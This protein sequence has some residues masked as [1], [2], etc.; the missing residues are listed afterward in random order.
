M[1]SPKIQNK[2]LFIAFTLLVAKAN[3]FQLKED[4]KPAEKDPLR[5]KDENFNFRI[6]QK[7]RKKSLWLSSKGKGFETKDQTIN[8]KFKKEDGSFDETVVFSLTLNGYL[9]KEQLPE[10]C[11]KEFDKMP[12]E[13]SWAVA[14]TKTS[15]CTYGRFPQVE[16]FEQK[17]TETLADDG[18]LIKLN[19]DEDG[20]QNFLRLVPQIQGEPAGT[21]FK[22]ITR[23]ED[24]KQISTLFVVFENENM[25]EIKEE[26]GKFEY[27]SRNFDKT[28]FVSF[29]R[30]FRLAVQPLIKQKF[31]VENDGDDTKEITFSFK[32]GKKL[33]KSEIPEYD[34]CKEIKDDEFNYVIAT[35]KNCIGAQTSVFK[36]LKIDGNTKE[37]SIIEIDLNWIEKESFTLLLQPK[38]RTRLDQEFKRI[39]TKEEKDKPT[40]PPKNILSIYINSEDVKFS[41]K[42]IEQRYMRWSICLTIAVIPAF[43]ILF[44]NSK[45]NYNGFFIMQFGIIFNFVSQITLA[46]IEW[47][48][49]E[50]L[51]FAQLLIIAL[52][53]LVAMYYC[54]DRRESL[55]KI[56]IIFSMIDYA[57]MAMLMSTSGTFFYGLINV[58][59]F[60]ILV[61]LIRMEKPTIP[62]HEIAVSFALSLT[63]LTLLGNMW[64]FTTSFNRIWYIFQGARVHDQRPGLYYMVYGLLFSIMSLMR[65]IL[66]DAL[67]WNRLAGYRPPSKVKRDLEQGFMDKGEQ[68]DDD[69]L[70]NT[71][72][73]RS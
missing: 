72:E 28:V 14:N 5:P 29:E 18:Y 24:K 11:Q 9:K 66:N 52:S 40:V 47:F 51:Y 16:L 34:S 21:L 31:K 32:Y 6:R 37:N 46:V 17:K 22:L 41:I 44:F 63:M 67:P 15:K 25:T 53:M 71:A 26:T 23:E 73:E 60:F 56:W 48:G 42:T 20:N 27:E 4:P 62:L 7:D 1:G 54:Q 65:L 58:L 3:S 13:E 8:L 55:T 45:F 61:Y 49:L 64:Y 39:F 50:D 10:I 12:F 70:R 33:K 59:C 19:I 68:E 38:T 69:D 57:L 35:E 36:Q 2:I 30:W 43:A